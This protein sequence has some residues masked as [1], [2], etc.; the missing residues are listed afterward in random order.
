MPHSSPPLL[1]RIQANL[2]IIAE[3]RREALTSVLHLALGRTQAD[4]ATRL[5]IVSR[6]QGYEHEFWTAAKV[7]L[8]L[9]SNGRTETRFGAPLPSFAVLTPETAPDAPDAVRRASPTPAVGTAT[10][11]MEPVLAAA[12]PGGPPPANL[13]AAGEVF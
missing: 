8:E 9:I 2:G 6:F 1:S 3:L 12:P 11:K 10:E 13:P 7:E 4:S 5:E